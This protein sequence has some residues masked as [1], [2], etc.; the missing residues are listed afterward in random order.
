MVD[1]VFSSV[2]ARYDLMNDIMSGGLHRLW[3]DR[4]VATIQRL[5]DLY[6]LVWHPYWLG[7]LNSPP[8]QHALVL[9]TARF[10][11]ENELGRYS[12]T[13]SYS[14]KRYRERRQV[15]DG[16]LCHLQFVSHAHPYL[17]CYH[18][19]SFCGNNVPSPISYLY[20][21]LGLSGWCRFFDP[22]LAC[23][24]WTW[25]EAQVSNDRLSFICFVVP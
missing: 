5:E 2:A 16:W 25:L 12:T 19:A 17:L 20:F 4:C 11:Q 7:R 21:F 13:V 8:E 24:I 15:G 3:K 18:Y 9:M 22:S 1:G 14:M 6:R 10:H 23:I